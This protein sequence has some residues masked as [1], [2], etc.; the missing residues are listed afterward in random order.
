MATGKSD[1]FDVISAIAILRHPGIR[2]KVYMAFKCVIVT[3]E[4][5]LLD[6]KATQAIVPAHDGE[7]GILTDRAPLLVKIGVGRLRVDVAG[8]KSLSFYVEGGVAQMKDN[9][10]TVLTDHAV[11]VTELS[12]EA[13]GK[14]LA[15]A[16]AKPVSDVTRKASIERARVKQ[17]LATK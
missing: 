10:L 12:A 13:A 8:G 16:T 14:D 11:P 15:D 9:N 5:Q 1:A 6:E 17:R 2:R 4:Q 7:I 3:P